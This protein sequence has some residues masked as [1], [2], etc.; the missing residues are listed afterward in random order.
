MFVCVCVCVVVVQEEYEYP[1]LTVPITSGRYKHV[2]RFLPATCTVREQVR[3]TDKWVWVQR[4]VVEFGAPPPTVD[5]VT[6]DDGQWG[7]WFF[8]LVGLAIAKAHVGVDMRTYPILYV[9]FSTP[10]L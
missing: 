7:Y 5:E 2:P 3:D 6:I 8:V 10:E 1:E 4:Y 9:C